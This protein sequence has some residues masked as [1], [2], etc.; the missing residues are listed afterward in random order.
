MR[1]SKIEL[2]ISTLETLAYSGP[3][4]L[5][6][7][8][9]KVNMNCNQLKPVLHDLIRKKLVEERT[10]NKRT[11]LYSATSK[12]RTILPYYNELKEMLGIPKDSLNF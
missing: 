1:R 3:L 5:T 8:G 2:Y 11:V 4:R 12:A 9:Y 7:I 10:F 6:R